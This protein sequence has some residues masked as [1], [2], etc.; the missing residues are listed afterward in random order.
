MQNFLKRHSQ[1][2][3]AIISSMGV[4]S[5]SYLA[6]K[7]TPKA[8]KLI[9]EE[10]EERFKNELKEDLTCLE[11][12]KISWK[13]YIPTFI[14]GFSTIFCIFGMAYLNKR[15]QNALLSAYAIL[16][17]SYKEYVEKTKELYGEEVDKNIK[18]EIVKNKI[19]TKNINL[20]DEQKLFFD[21][22]TM[23]YFY[24]TFDKVIKAEEMLNQEFAA[25]GN[26]S[27]NDFYKFIGIEPLP[28]SSNIG[29]TDNGEYHEI[30]FTH[31]K[32]IM[33]D[34]LECWII[35]TDDPLLDYY[36]Y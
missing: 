9:Q 14:S 20:H 10:K 35:I 22:Q 36:N 30:T 7:A 12:I 32:V 27:V 19:D 3:L 2:I 24:S 11:V 34:G 33:D 16:N 13:P 21:Y 25:V 15:S 17:N 31:Q 28:Y 26:V 29:W 18:Q 8:M 1:I 6:I 23:R 4:I 5:T